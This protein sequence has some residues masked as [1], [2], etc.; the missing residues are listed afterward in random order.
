MK[1]KNMFLLLIPFLLSCTKDYNPY[2]EEPPE[3]GTQRVVL[4]E[5]FVATWC[6]NCPVAIEAAYELL[7]ENG[8]DKVNVLVYHPTDRDT[9]GTDETD[10]RIID[11]YKEGK[12][13][14]VCFADGIIKNYG[15]D[16]G[17]YD[18]YKEAFNTRTKILSP[19]KITVSGS[20][21]EKSI[22]ANINTV[23]NPPS[24]SLKV[25]FLLV[26][27]LITYDHQGDL[28]TENYMV[29]DIL[30]EESINASKGATFNINRKFNIDG[31]WKPDNMG[32]IVL[33]Q[34]DSNKEIIQSSYSGGIY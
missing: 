33:I 1:I 34:D 31:R 29:R 12:V 8:S 6:H 25:R 10:Y 30:E 27:S 3:Q 14:P 2:Y 20:I 32:I 13:Y 23:D 5:L 19:F 21:N 4:F 28:L 7:A 11:Y 17:T 15:G 26:E 18:K 22:T 16:D 9:F 24:A